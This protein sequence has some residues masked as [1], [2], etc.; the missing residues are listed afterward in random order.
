[1]ATSNAVAVD[2]PHNQSSAQ[3]RTSR[4]L[5]PHELLRAGILSDPSTPAGAYKRAKGLVRQGGF[6]QARSI[7][8]PHEKTDDIKQRPQ[9]VELLGV[10]AMQMGG[11]WRALFNEALCDY[12]EAGDVEGQARVH[13]HLGE[14]CLDAGQFKDAD[15]HLRNA[16]T[17]FHT[18]QQKDRCANVLRLRA[19]VRVRAGKFV[20]AMNRVDEALRIL[21]TLGRA[22]EEAL[23]RIDRAVI[24]AYMGEAEQCAKELVGAERLLAT[25]GNRIDRV[26]ARLRRAETLFILGDAERAVRGLRSIMSDVVALDHVCTRAWAHQL[27]GRALAQSDSNAARRNLMRARHLYESIESRFGLANTEVFLSILEHRMGLN[28]LSRLRALSEA[29]MGEWPMFAA[30]LHLARAEVAV[31]KKPDVSKR[32]LFEARDFAERT[33]NR[34][35]VGLI[36]E[37]LRRL[38]LVSTEEAV[39]LTQLTAEPAA[40]VIKPL[41][42]AAVSPGYRPKGGPLRMEYNDVTGGEGSRMTSAVRFIDTRC[43]TTPSLT[44]R[45]PGRRR[46]RLA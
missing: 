29:P 42:C 14:M 25:S 7:L 46:R 4:V 12:T 3:N 8:L 10:C 21:V 28:P 19:R 6:S 32:M 37:A 17:L 9:I 40:A 41:V 1:M 2:L 45:V 36:D 15:V 13:R 11:E 5:L 16:G 30:F 24:L 23:C 18:L 43:R 20:Q 39:R 33:K 44:L 31:E 35:L 22:R 34:Y 38:K 26:Q 27:L